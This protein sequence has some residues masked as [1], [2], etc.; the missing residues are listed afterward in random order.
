[1]GVPGFFEIPARVKTHD[2]LILLFKEAVLNFFKLGG[3]KKSRIL[4]KMGSSK[5]KF[6]FHFT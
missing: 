4:Q 3:D 6:L 2:V 1:M 5:T